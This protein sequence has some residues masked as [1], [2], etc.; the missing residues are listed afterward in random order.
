MGKD[1]ADTYPEARR[2]FEEVDDALGEKLS[3]LIW[4]GPEETLTLTANAQPALMAVSL[5][6]I[7]ALESRGFLLRDKVAYVAG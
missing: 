3:T 4:E 7:R 2:V 5:A 6:A 1:L